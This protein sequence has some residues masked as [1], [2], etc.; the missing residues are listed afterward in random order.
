MTTETRLANGKKLPPGRIPTLL[1]SFVFGLFGDR[2]SGK[3]AAMAYYGIQEAEAGR[4]I[5]YYPEDFDLKIPGAEAMSPADLVSMPDRLTGATVLIDEVQEVLSKFRTNAIASLLLMAFFRQTRKRGANVIFTSNDPN[6][7]NSALSTQTDLHAMCRMVTD[8]RCYDVGYHLRS[9][10]DTVRMRIKDTNGKHGLIGN[11][12]DGRKGFVQ[13]LVGIGDVY[14][15]YNTG[16]IA[17][18][19]EVMGLN[20]RNLLEL[21]AQEKLGSIKTWENFDIKLI[22]EIIPSLVANGYK[23]IIPGTFVNTLQNEMDIPEKPLPAL[24]SRELGKRL[25]A[26]GL[27]STRK[28]KGMVYQLPPKEHLQAWADGVWSPDN[29]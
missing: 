7:I 18:P 5:F 9:C 13:H 1:Q 25:K 19:A 20:K 27:V 21:R 15:L 14:P 26:I 11:R 2:G 22:T 24:D 6:A 10:A 29:D 12:K 4:P 3:S 28:A 17:D 23:S 16:A 8:P